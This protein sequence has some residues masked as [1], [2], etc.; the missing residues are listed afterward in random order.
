MTVRRIHNAQL[1]LRDELVFGS[2]RH[3]N[4]LITEIDHNPGSQWRGS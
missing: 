3:E 4:G 2:L 1:V